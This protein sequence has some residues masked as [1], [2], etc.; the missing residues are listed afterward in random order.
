MC[1]LAAAAVITVPA[2][3]AEIGTVAAVNPEMKGT[4]PEEG[5]RVLF[6]GNRLISDE[7]IETS[8]TGTGQLLFLDQTTLTV[9]PGSEIVLDRYVYDPDRDTGEIAVSLTR[10]ALRFIGGKLTKKKIGVVKTPAATIGIRGGIALI[11]VRNG[12]TRV[13]NIASDFVEIA[14]FGD[15]DGN[16][17]DD[18]VTGTG[19]RLSETGSGGLGEDLSDANRVVLSRPN[20]LGIAS[21][22]NVQFSGIISAKDLESS[23]RALEGTGAGGLRRISPGVV[24][25]RRNAKIAAVN[26]AATGGAYLEPVST[27]GQPVE[28]QIKLDSFLEDPS[29]RFDNLS[30][31]IS[32][33]IVKPPEPTL[34]QPD[35]ALIAGLRGTASYAG[36]ATGTMTATG[37]IATL[38]NV[39]GAFALTYDFTA[40]SGAL[41]FNLLNN[42]FSLGVSARPANAA[43]YSGSDPIFGGP[44]RITAQG[45]FFVGTND[46]RGITAGQYTIDLQSQNQAIRGSFQGDRK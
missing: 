8:A 34:V 12:E 41:S 24:S 40:R 16:G 14:H 22:G 13:V 45:G 37:S 46:P 6:L 43:N 44:D 3:A 30:T 15:T 33:G 20:A 5:K 28:D 10:G 36:T 39:S 38:Q 21:S 25:E 29:T 4:P 11:E 2:T 23:F 42:T 7:R 18:G 31:D 26:S 35:P 32:D 9:A 27:T 17:L 1:L 19:S